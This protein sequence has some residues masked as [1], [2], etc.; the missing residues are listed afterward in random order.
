MSSEDKEAQED[1]LLALASIY[2]DEFKRAESVQGGEIRV[3]VDLPQ[4]FSIFV[5]GSSTDNLQDS[6][7]ECTVCFLPPIVLNFELPADYPSTAPPVFALSSKWLSLL[8]LSALCKHLDNLWEENQGCVVLF[9]WIR[10]LKEETLA[11]LNITSPYK[12]KIY[13][14]RKEP[15]ITNKEE[16]CYSIAASATAQEET[17]D[18]RAV[19]DVESLSSLIREILDFDRAQGEK[20]FNNKMYLCN[21]CFSEKL[22]KECMYFMDCRH[23][24]CKACLKDYFEVQIRDGQVHCLN[25]PEPKCSCVATPGQVKELVE[26]QLFAR[27]DRLLLQSSLDLMADVVYCPRPC[28]QT[29]VMQEPSCSMGICPKCSYAFCTL[30]KMTYHGVS[31]CKVTAEKLVDLRNEYLEADETT[32]KFLE[33]RYGKRVIQKALEEMESKEW[34]EKNSKSCPC[35]GTPIEKLDGCNKMT[36]TGCMQYFCWLCMGSLSRANPYRHFNDPAS[37]CFN[38]LFQTMQNDADLWDDD[39]DDDD[40]D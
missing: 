10:F 12:P 3:S 7:F 39:D 13:D 38:L 31:P 21:I 22:G 20:C 28:C 29:P 18:V 6:K 26:E 25:C 32:K 40:E 35:C 24:Y 9:A 37:P 11:Y 1:E 34:L 16:V 15:N 5:S 30:C 19:Q 8:Q 14:H 4:N 2:E 17:L 33:Q 27:Y 23:V 36:C